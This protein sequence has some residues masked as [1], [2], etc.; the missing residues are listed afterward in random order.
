MNWW[1]EKTVEFIEYM[2]RAILWDIRL[3]GYTDNQ[4]KLD[5]LRGLADKFKCDL[6]T[7]KKRI[8]NLR[9]AFRRE[10]KSQTQKKS[11]SSPIN[12]SKWFAYD[13]LIFLLDVDNPR[14]GYSSEV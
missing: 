2:K 10:H 13:L 3:T 9:N 11:G 7:V 4:A 6:A 5:A 8:K 1:Q 14:L 12:R